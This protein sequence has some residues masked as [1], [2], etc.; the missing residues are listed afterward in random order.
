MGGHLEGE[1]FKIDGALAKQLALVGQIRNIV[2]QTTNT[3]YKI[4]DG[5]GSIEV[6]LWTDVVQDPEQGPTN[7]NPDLVEGA[8]VRV[9]GKSGSFN[10]KRYV[11]SNVIR[12]IT[13]HN[14]ISY[15]L[16][17]ATA[18][19]LYY[20]RGPLGGNVAASQGGANGGQQKEDPDFGGAD[21][22]GYSDVAKR[23]FK[24]LR[25]QPQTNEGVH[26]QVIAAQLGLDIA[27]AA[28]AGDDLLSG[29]LIYTTET[30]E[31]WAV[32]EAD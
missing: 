9:W 4:D 26:Q 8:Y 27:E 14:E 16:L 15:H 19:H 5:T 12:P 18:V 1:N 25:T 7:T 23:V 3:T 24:F 30:D 2:S 28:R 11:V 6:K 32:M 17:K 13:D 22:R 31:T 21:M 10:D 29:G 20:T